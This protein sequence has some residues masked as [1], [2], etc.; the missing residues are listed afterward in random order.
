MSFNSRKGY[1]ENR[2]NFVVALG[3][4]NKTV[5]YIGGLNE[6]PK[7]IGTVKNSISGLETERIGEQDQGPGKLAF[8][9][10]YDGHLNVDEMNEL[11]YESM[12]EI[13]GTWTEKQMKEIKRLIL[14]FCEEIEDIAMLTMQYAKYTQS[15][16]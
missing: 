10:V 7:L 6:T 12:S 11:Y 5:F 3:S 4:M 16:N 9:A 2:W 14:S 13:G 1:L 8:V 15:Y